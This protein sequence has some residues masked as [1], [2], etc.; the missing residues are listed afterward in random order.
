MKSKAIDQGYIELKLYTVIVEGPAAQPCNHKEEGGGGKGC[1]GIPP[2]LK[3]PSI[4]VILIAVHQNYILLVYMNA[5]ATRSSLK[6]SYH[7]VLGKCPLPGKH[8]GACF[9]CANGERP[10]PG[11]RPG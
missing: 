8:P 2:F 4:K 6:Q 9:G 5:E 11:K 1:T 7:S 10:L 3:L